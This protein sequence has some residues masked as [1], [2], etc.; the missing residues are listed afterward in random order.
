MGMNRGRLAGLVA[1]AGLLGHGCSSEERVPEEAAILPAQVTASVLTELD[2]FTDSLESESRN[3]RFTRA[4][5]QIPAFSERERGITDKYCIA[6][7]YA[8]RFPETSD[9]WIDTYL[10]FV[11]EKDS[12]VWSVRRFTE[13]GGCCD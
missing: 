3:V 8:C 6:I 4:R 9:R 12:V 1:L 2:R 13:P 7:N 5:R 11:A 10:W